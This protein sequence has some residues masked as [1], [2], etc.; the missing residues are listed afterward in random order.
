MSN[1]GSITITL[2]VL[3]LHQITAVW[4]DFPKDGKIAIHYMVRKKTQ[5]IIKNRVRRSDQF[6]RTEARPP[7][8]SD[9]ASRR[10]VF[11]TRRCTGGVPSALAK[12]IER[13]ASEFERWL[14]VVTRIFTA[15]S[16]E[17]STWILD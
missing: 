3:F 10:G 15:S 13:I 1:Y 5:R 17:V 9:F 14:L 16:K 6:P 7:A 4:G 2:Q 8:R 12:K 11:L